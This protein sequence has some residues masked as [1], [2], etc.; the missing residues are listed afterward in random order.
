MWY[1]PDRFREASKNTNRIARTSD[2]LKTVVEEASSEATQVF[3]TESESAHEES[4]Y[5]PFFGLLQV[6]MILCLIIILLL[7]HNYEVGFSFR[8]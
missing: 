3:E 5:G 6:R 8:C 4:L 2:I 1:S 7:C